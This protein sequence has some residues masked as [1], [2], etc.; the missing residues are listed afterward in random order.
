MHTISSE[1]KLF[2]LWLLLLKTRRVLYRARE[3][4]LAQYS[5]TPEQA[6][7]LFIN[8]AKKGKVSQTEIAR[9][10]AREPHTISGIIHR[11]E[12]KGLVRKYEDLKLKNVKRI[13]VTKKG[14]EVEKK[15]NKR[16]TINNIMSTL[17]EQERS[18]LWSILE[19]LLSAG[20]TELDKYYLSPY[21]RLSEE[22]P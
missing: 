1:D 2:N 9:L 7:I 13:D 18:Q 19:K 8:K 3:K 20:I 17:T 11:M 15:V 6:E 22:I 5:I 12:K 14:G 10:M 21:T 4:E 16:I